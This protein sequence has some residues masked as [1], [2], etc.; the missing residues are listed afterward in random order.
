[1]NEFLET[2]EKIVKMLKT[3]YD[4]EIPVNIYD[5]GLIY[6]IDLADDGQLAI[7]M[8]LTAPNCP[9]V[10]FIVEDV[11]MKT[12]SVEGVKDVTV[13]IVYE[14]A[15]DKSMMSEEAQLELGFL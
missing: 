5:L 9:A 13:N 7:D 8:T 15:W 12:A 3:V 14:P 6:K 4:P 1:M 11:R 10:D 2:E